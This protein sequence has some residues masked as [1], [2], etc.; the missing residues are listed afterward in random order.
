MPDCMGWGSE[1]VISCFERIQHNG[2]HNANMLINEKAK[3]R[4]ILS[5]PHPHVCN[6]RNLA[7]SCC[8]SG[9]KICKWLVLQ[10]SVTLLMKKLTQPRAQ[11]INQSCTSYTHTYHTSDDTRQR[12]ERKHCPDENAESPQWRR[13]THYFAIRRRL[14][15]VQFS[16]CINEH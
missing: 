12:R 14:R 2:L 7:I 1:K 13:W 8:G 3:W 10:L 4:Q 9:K 6:M 11:M 16:I 5:L 15:L